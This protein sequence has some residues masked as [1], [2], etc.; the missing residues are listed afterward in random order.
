MNANRV[1]GKEKF[2]EDHSRRD[3]QQKVHRVSL[4]W[5]QGILPPVCLV[6][7]GVENEQEEGVEDS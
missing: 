2:V 1:C 6:G 3:N 7:H 4:R 5:N